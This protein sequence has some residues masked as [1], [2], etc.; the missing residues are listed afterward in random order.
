MIKCFTLFLLFCFNLIGQEINPNQVNRGLEFQTQ[1]SISEINPVFHFPP[2]NQ[3]T[4]LVCWSFSTI[5]FI[6][7]EMQRL[8]KDKVKLS[9][10]Y[11]VY[12]GFIEKA[13]Y[14]VKT[15][16][17][18]RFSPGDLFGTVINV[19]N[20]YGIVPENV[21][22]GNK[23]DNKTYNHT[24]L[25]KKLNEYMEKVRSDSLWKEEI[26]VHRVKEILNKY[27][28]EPPQKFNFKDKEYSP[29][30][31]ANE[32]VNIHWNDY[33]KITSFKSSPFFQFTK[34]A[35][36]DNWLPDSSYFNVPLDMFYESILKSIKNNYSLAIDGDM[37]EPGR[38]GAKDICFIPE[39]DIPISA[40]T[41]DAREYRFE[42]KLTTDDHLMHIIGYQNFNGED[43]FLVKDSW[44]DA[45]EGK[46]KGYFFFS[47]AYVKLKV[48]AFLVHKE[49]ISDLVS[50]N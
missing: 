4:T 44:R 43:W 50:K 24:K 10:M 28:G 3:D 2:I 36:P 49:I 31:F 13:K 27:L 1:N 20:K 37:T 17:K 6:E 12:F 30:E 46:Y 41:Q 18:S 14:F 26:V 38:M 47:E 40:I 8:E 39:Y 29:L 25:Y 9:V 48:L 32:I 23:S 19:I 5:S 45:F 16:G 35:V 42:K 22:S 15:H 34:L 33:I 21:Y 11:P 7:S